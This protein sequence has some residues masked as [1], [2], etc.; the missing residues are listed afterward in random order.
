MVLYRHTVLASRRHEGTKVPAHGEIHA[1]MWLESE[2]REGLGKQLQGPATH[3][4]EVLPKSRISSVTPLLYLVQIEGD[5]PEK[6]KF[7]SALP[8]WRS[9]NAPIP[10]VQLPMALSCLNTNSSLSDFMRLSCISLT[11]ASSVS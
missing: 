7:S 2:D 8:P 5:A 11:V 3:L 6:C 4:R 9:T 10:G 1:M